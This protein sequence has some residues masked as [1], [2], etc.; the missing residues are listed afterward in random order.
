L[1][2]LDKIVEQKQREVAQLPA[3]RIAAGKAVD[4]F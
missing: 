3:R 2:I 1:N 4:G